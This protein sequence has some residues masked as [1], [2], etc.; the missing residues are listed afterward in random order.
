[1]SVHLPTIDL[2]ALAILDISLGDQ[3]LEQGLALE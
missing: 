3:F 2:E 1:M